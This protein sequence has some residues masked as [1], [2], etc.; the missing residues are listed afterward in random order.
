VTREIPEDV[1]AAGYLGKIVKAVYMG[2][3]AEY[4]VAV[5]DAVLLA[6]VASPAEHGIF[7]AGDEVGITFS[8]DVAH[9]I[10]TRNG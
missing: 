7:S 1:H 10:V 8:S 2:S 3:V 9:P 5:G 6:V 4:D